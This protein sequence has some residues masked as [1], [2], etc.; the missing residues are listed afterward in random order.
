MLI[1][2]RYTLGLA[3]CLL[4]YGCGAPAGS[5]AGTPDSPPERIVS[6]SGAVTETLY[7][8][9]HGE[10]I[11]G[12]DVTSSY[13][14]A[15]Q[16]LPDLGHVSQLNAEGILGLRPD[17]IIAEAAEENNPV[18]QQ[19]SRSG[20]ETLFVPKP[21]S[22]DAPVQMATAI[23]ERL[24]DPNNQL[25]DLVRKVETQQQELENR[26]S[27]IDDRP[28]VLFI[29]ARGKGRLMVA[30]A[31]T[32]AEAMIRAAGGENA[33]N[34]FEGFQALSAEGLIEAKPEV[35]LMFES[36]LRSLDGVETLLALPGIDQTPAGRNRSI[37]TMDGHYLLGFGPRAAAAALELSRRLTAIQ[38]I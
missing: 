31:G 19:L 30:G 38:N 1:L 11:V 29:Y 21:N 6:L 27:G 34:A 32:P 8:L 9:G 24:G 15:V 17:L 35:I 25:E 16:Q 22:L 20:I 3:Y 2:I 12:V 13:P 37:I 14:A 7:A 26:I 5:E 4:L 10:K 36:G 28:R 18:L 23:A 33:I